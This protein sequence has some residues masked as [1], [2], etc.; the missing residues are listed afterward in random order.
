VNREDAF[1]QLCDYRS[2]ASAAQK[3]P[4]FA[5]QRGPVLVVLDKKLITVNLILR[6]LAP[7]L[8]LISARTIAQHGATWPHLNRALAIIDVGRE[9]EEHQWAGRGPAFP[10]SLLDPVISEVAIPLWEAD[11][12]RQ[13]VSD[14]ATSLNKF[15][16]D[17]LSRHDVYDSKL[18]TEAFSDDP[19]KSGKPRLRCPG[20]HR[21]VTVKDQ[22]AGARQLANGAFLAIRNPAHHMI[23]DWNP[24]TAFH[25]LTIL[26]HV[27]HYFRD[28]DVV[29][30][31]PP[32]PDIN[33][34]MAAYQAQ[35]VKSAG[36]RLRATGEGGTG[37]V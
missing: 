8:P 28:W 2:Q 22:Q 34:L 16:Q 5:G 35:T 31:V 23:G 29:E 4:R 21:L 27:A 17:Q 18:M 7:D 26:S 3:L 33:A 14:A 24:A 10:L 25:H 6:E 36:V 37:R 1:R 13:A 19:P 9:M 11:K 30:Y 20:D 15:A 12:F 32:P